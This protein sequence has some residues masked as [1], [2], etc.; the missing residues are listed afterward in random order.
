MEVSQAFKKPVY[1]VKERNSD[2]VGRGRN[3]EQAKARLGWHK[4]FL[5]QR[6]KKKRERPEVLSFLPPGLRGGRGL[7]SEPLGFAN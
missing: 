2:I 4:D 7:L 6:R 5:H 1:V 3:P